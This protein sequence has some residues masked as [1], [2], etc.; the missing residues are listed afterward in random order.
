MPIHIAKQ[1][2]RGCDLI[3][4]LAG[5]MERKSYGIELL[6]KHVAPRLI[7]SVDRFEV[8]H[9]AFLL[10]DS[11]LI[12]LRDKTPANQRHFWIDFGNGQRNI[13]QAQLRRTGTFEELQALA[14]YLNTQPPL[15]IGLISTSVHLRRVKFCCLRIP[16]FNERNVWLWPVPEEQSSFKKAG[17]WKRPSHSS[18]LLSEYIKLAAYHLHYH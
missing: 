9:T 14:G 13:F 12:P 18:Y 5:R 8:R 1:P 7:L 6:N 11:D 17:W 2:V 10:Q 15:Q 16:F 3:F 4:V